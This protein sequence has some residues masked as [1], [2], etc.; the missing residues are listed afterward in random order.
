MKATVE[1][2]STKLILDFTNFQ[3]GDVLVFS[4][5][6]DEAQNYDPNETDW[7][8]STQGSTRL[9]RGSS[10][11]IHCSSRVH[12]AALRRRYR[13]KQVPEQLRF[14]VAADDLR[15]QRMTSTENAIALQVPLSSSACSQADIA[16]RI[17]YVDNNY[18]LTLDSGEVRL[19]NDPTGLFQQVNGSFVSTGHKT[20]TNSQGEYSFGTR[21]K[22]MPGIYQVRETQPDGYL[23]VGATKAY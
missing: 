22:L 19:A 8:F 15:Y 3:A 12:R 18:S 17:V 21:L 14:R 16:G 9:P 1:D 2:G 23:S 20:T 6:V 11:R 7:L 10:S 13:P 4:I 5:D